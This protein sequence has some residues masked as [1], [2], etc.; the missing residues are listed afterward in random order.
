[1][2]GVPGHVQEMTDALER[3][4]AVGN[5]ALVKTLHRIGLAQPLE[6]GRVQVQGHPDLAI[7]CTR[8]GL[9]ND[10]LFVAPA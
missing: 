1:M 8:N 9:G 7:V 10:Q 3:S 5:I 4:P 6:Q 2:P